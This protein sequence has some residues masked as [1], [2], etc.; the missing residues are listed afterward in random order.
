VEF[1]HWRSFCTG[2]A[3]ALAQ[4][5]EFAKVLH[6]RGGAGNVSECSL[7]K[8]AAVQHAYIMICLYKHGLMLSKP[9]QFYHAAVAGVK[10]FF[11]H[12]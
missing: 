7:T 10:L 1:L 11:N 6:W 4:T 8:I 9:P 3:F 12:T 5:F 2:A